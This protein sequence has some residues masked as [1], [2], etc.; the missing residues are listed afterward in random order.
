MSVFIFYMI[1]SLACFPYWFSKNRPEGIFR[2]SVVIFL[3]VF[4]Y[5]LIFL[6]WLKGIYAERYN[7]SAFSGC[8]E[9]NDGTVNGTLKSYDRK[10]AL[11]LIPMEE[12]LLLNDNSIKR[13]LLLDILKEDMGKHS[14]LLK[15]ALNSDDTETSHYAASGIVEVKRK[16]VQS[17]QE[18]NRKYESLKTEDTLISYA[19]AL[20]SY[21]ECGLLDETSGRKARET[22]QEVLKE[23]LELYNQEEEFFVDRINYEIEAGEFDLAGSYCRKFMKVHNQGEKPYLMY[24][25]LFYRCRDRKSFNDILKALEA[26]SVSI[27][28]NTWSIIEF[29]TEVI[30]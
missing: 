25:K 14:L 21:Q 23:L 30:S 24:L 18:W 4:G 11:N 6:L 16:L 28:H 8:K 13:M 26:S 5:L 3:P 9:Q 19:Y 22:Y 1:L 27:S 12:A 2:L 17:V 20:K 29:W 7:N 15:I 10:K